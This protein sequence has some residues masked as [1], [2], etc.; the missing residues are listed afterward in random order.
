MSNGGKL[1]KTSEVA[2]HLGVDT[3]SVARYIR[4]GLLPAISTAGGHHRVY[5]ADVQAFLQGR[6]R[7][8]RDADGAVIIALV[9]QK[10]GVGKT[11]ATINLGVLLCQMEMRVLLADLDPQGHLTW[12]MGHNPERLEQTLYTALIKDD[13]VS[14]SQVILKSSLGPDVAPMNIVASEA[15]DFLRGK[16]N[17][18]SRLAT[19]L[20]EVRDRY[21]YILL[22][23]GPNLSALTINALYAADYIV[24]PTE[25]EMLS[26]KGL[27]LLLQRVDDARRHFNSR[28]QVAG[29][30]A[31]KV[32]SRTNA[33]R[34]MDEALR[35]GL[36]R[37]GIRAFQSPIKHSTRYSEVSINRQAMVTAHPRSEHAVAYKRLLA[38]LLQVVGGPAQARLSL[39]DVSGEQ[40][41]TDGAGAVH[42]D[43]GSAAEI[44]RVSRA[45]SAEGTKSR[46]NGARGSAPAR[47]ASR[48]DK[49]DEQV[50][51]TSRRGRAR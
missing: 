51:P 42:T 10:G 27:Q 9:N 28:L 5:E 13:E 4:E 43:D 37:R 35:E 29:A 38:E 11:T 21:D 16:P 20:K 22:D 1:L 48:S 18:G 46:G 3:G 8:G 45:L 47:H 19:A 36:G 50:E 23:P 26:I 33:A 39:L 15:E 40:G 14:V 2:E 24:I 30:V 49:Q 7:T 25:L 32:Q 17:W 41:E 12:S 34:V 44:T 6:A 31:M